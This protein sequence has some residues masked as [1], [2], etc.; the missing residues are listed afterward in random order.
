MGRVSRDRGLHGGVRRRRGRSGGIRRGSLG[1]GADGG[2]DRDRDCGKDGAVGGA[3]SVLRG[4]AGDGLDAGGVDGACRP[5]GLPGWGGR[6]Q[7]DRR[8]GHES[9]PGAPFFEGSDPVDEGGESDGGAL[10]FELCN[11]LS[12]T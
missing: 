2:A 6:A 3:L 8:A 1:D 10:H 7:E 12:W 4:A 9:R 11:E 5:L